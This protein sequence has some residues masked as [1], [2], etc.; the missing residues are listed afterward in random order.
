MDCRVTRRGFL[1]GGAVA[2]SA[3]WGCARFGTPSSAKVNWSP[4]LETYRDEKTGALV[5]RLT[6]G[7][8]RDE[9]IY[10][11]HPMWVRGMEY[12]VFLS[13]RSGNGM[14][15]HILETRTGI[16]K[17][18]S[19]TAPGTHVVARH[20]A[21]IYALEE[22][23]IKAYDVVAAFTSGAPGRWVADW[24]ADVGHAGMLSLDATERVLYSGFSREADKKWG[25]MALDLPRGTWE[26]VTEVDFLVGHV[27]ANPF[28]TGLVSFCWE[29][30]GDAPQ[31]T[32]LVDVKDG[33]ARPFYK[34]TYE[35][36]VTHEVWWGPDHALFTIW[37][38]DDAHRKQPHGV[39]LVDR[40]TG[41][42][43]ILSQYPAWHTAGSPDMRWVM[44]DDFDRNLWLIDP[45]TCERRLLTQGHNTAPANT[46]PHASFT[47]DSRGIV[48]TSSKWGSADICVVEIPKWESLP[49]E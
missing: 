15:P 30:S 17:P 33:V 25:V 35:E 11:T 24:P 21:A 40:N 19:P 9:V 39:G 18:L 37:P 31:R 27:Q 7:D 34:E 28:V 2:V 22:G 26:I 32:W 36:W 43:R 16:V 49:A 45:K 8:A 46:H 47:P 13:D 42:H 14:R 41:A 5:R 3:L 4:E 38:Y 29:T 20:S 48:F 1:A 23:C 10:Q 12:L 44:G 6:Q